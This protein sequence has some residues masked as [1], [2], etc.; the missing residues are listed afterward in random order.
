MTA[1]LRVEQTRATIIS[2]FE[3]TRAATPEARFGTYKTIESDYVDW[4]PNLQ[5]RYVPLQNFTLRANYSTTIGRPRISDLVGRFAINDLAQT[6]SFSNPSLKPQISR[7]YDVSLEYYFKPVG[8]ASIGAFRKDIKNYVTATSFRITGNE[9]GLDLTDYVNWQG[10]SRVNSGDGTVEGMEFNYSQQLSF[11]PGV[12]RGF[13]VMGNWTVLTSAGD[14]NGVV[15]SLPFKN[16][17]TGMRPRSGNAGLTYNYQRWD[18]RLMWNYADTYLASLNAGDP[19]SSEFI[20][21]RDQ[22]DFFAR[23]KISRNLNVFLDVINLLEENRGRY[24]GLYREDRRAQTNLFPRSIST[25][26]QARF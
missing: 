3:N 14:Y 17:L 8:V 6:V 5:F 24:S 12:F 20:G 11:L 13:G 21:R 25:G 22:F 18:L 26:V 15:T 2:R 19:S 9:F 10:S 4:F 23:F 7:N 1:G 16:N